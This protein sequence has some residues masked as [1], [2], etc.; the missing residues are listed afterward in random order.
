M[1]QNAFTQSLQDSLKYNISRKTSGIKL[2]FCMLTDTKT[3]L[4][5]WSSIPKVPKITSLQYLDKKEARDKYNVLNEDDHRNFL[6]Q[7]PSFLVAIST[8]GQSTK[9]NKVAISSKYL[10]K[11]GRHEVR[12]F[13]CR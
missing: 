12:F 13:A 3:V 11:E 6:K 10:K 2:I 8:H 7:I 1:C 9:N 5:L 4:V